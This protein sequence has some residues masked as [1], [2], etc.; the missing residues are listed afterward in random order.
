[1]STFTPDEVEF[2]RT[3]GNAWCSKIWLARWDPVNQPV[4][5]K[6]DEKV[7]DFMV[8]KV[9][10]WLIRE[11]DYL[12]FKSYFCIHDRLDITKVPRY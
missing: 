9:D 2:M 4:D 12:L 5:F 7:K 3:R 1:M 11:L 10:F 8:A 6:D